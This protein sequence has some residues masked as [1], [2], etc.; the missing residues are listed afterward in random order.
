MPRE[1]TED[2]STERS[3]GQIG[4]A[5]A[6]STVTSPSQEQISHDK[7]KVSVQNNHLNKSNVTKGKGRSGK[8][9]TEPQAVAVVENG[10][11]VRKERPVEGTH[12][13]D[14]TQP[15]R[16]SHRVKVRE[17][18]DSLSL[19]KPLKATEQSPPNV[20][21][22]AAIANRERA[23]KSAHWGLVRDSS[24]EEIWK[25]FEDFSQVDSQIKSETAAPTKCLTDQ[26]SANG[27][28]VI[29]PSKGKT[30]C[31]IDRGSLPISAP[32][33]TASPASRLKEG[34]ILGTVVAVI[35]GFFA[36]EVVS[37]QRLS[38]HSSQQLPQT[39]ITDQAAT[40]PLP[41][42]SDLEGTVSSEVH[43]AAIPYFEDEA[44]CTRHRKQWQ[45]D[46]C[47]DAEHSPLF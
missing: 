29:K 10:H 46:Q 9:A 5:A 42:A 30:R 36:V 3:T 27:K 4:Q 14:A 37:R 17:Q 18:T 33:R 16:S 41:I 45:D 26:V 11:P 39:E 8:G 47:W 7:Q 15:V 12:G 44:E 23:E 13:I 19:S 6:R 20:A 43:P 35:L 28:S 25:P 32:P 40:A 31:Q 21:P 34:L 22:S 24:L 38:T 1:F 2:S